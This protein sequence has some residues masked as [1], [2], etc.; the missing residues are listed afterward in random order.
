LLPPCPLH[1]SSPSSLLFLHIPTLLLLLPHTALP[2]LPLALAPSPHPTDTSCFP[3]PLPP[4][5][6][7]LLSPSS[8]SIPTSPA[9]LLLH[10]SHSTHTPAPPLPH[11]TLLPASLTLLLPPR[12]L[13]SSPSSAP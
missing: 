3:P 13:P 1:S 11:S 12:T 7:P 8:P 4:S 2:P 10:Y 9:A 6:F 5:P